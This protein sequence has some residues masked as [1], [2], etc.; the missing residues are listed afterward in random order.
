MSRKTVIV[1]G[2]AWGTALACVA[3]RAGQPTAL[4]CRDAD[5][6]KALRTQ[7]RNPRYL[8]DLTLQERIEATTDDHVLEGA[9]TIILAIPAQS[10]RTALPALAPHVA[11]DA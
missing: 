5:V 7:G 3:M 2:G 1:G 10:L 11:G 9:G 4:L 6:A 8:P